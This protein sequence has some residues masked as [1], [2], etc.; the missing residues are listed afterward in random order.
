V[1][2]NGNHDNSQLLSKSVDSNGNHENSLFLSKSV[3]LNGSHE[4]SQLFMI[5]MLTMKPW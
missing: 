1:D 5:T 3:D 4:N 2:P